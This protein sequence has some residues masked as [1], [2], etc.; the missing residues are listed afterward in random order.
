MFSWSPACWHWLRADK[1]ITLDVYRSFSLC[2]IYFYKSIQICFCAAYCTRGV[3]VLYKVFRSGIR[4]SP[5]SISQFTV[6]SRAFI[7]LTVADK[8]IIF[9]K[10]LQN[11]DKCFCGRVS[12]WEGA[13]ILFQQS[14]MAHI[15]RYKVISSVTQRKQMLWA[16]VYPNTLQH[17]SFLQ[18]A[19]APH[20]T[21]TQ[22]DA[23]ADGLML[24]PCFCRWNYYLLNN[25][26]YNNFLLLRWCNC[27][28]L[29]WFIFHTHFPENQLHNSCQQRRQ[30][31]A[32]LYKI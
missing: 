8:A 20:Q 13:Q 16:F 26:D 15:A 27:Y 7:I 9:L 3:N 24:R 4:F 28:V 14:L 25:K 6:L 11:V 18:W 31:D 32:I 22:H 12:V 2:W 17:P 30:Y 23:Q 29:I 19:E 1:P 5:N 21:Q 10:Q